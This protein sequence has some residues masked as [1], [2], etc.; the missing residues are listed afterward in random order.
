MDQKPQNP[1]PD[2]RIL[3]HDTL[4]AL[5]GPKEVRRD[6]EEYVIDSLVHGPFS[7]RWMLLSYWQGKE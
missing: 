2:A 4:S 6:L 5:R 3:L 1:V 7:P